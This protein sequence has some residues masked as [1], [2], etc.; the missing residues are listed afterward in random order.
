MRRPP[1]FSTA[2]IAVTLLTPSILF[3]WGH[4]GH[5]IV[6]SLAQTRLT[7]NAKNGIRSLI[8]DAGLASISNWADDVRPDRDETYNWHFVDI[9]KDASGFSDERDCFLPNNKHKGSATD[10]HNC[11]VDRIE[12]FKTVLSNNNAAT[13]RLS[14]T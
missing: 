9:S 5:E 12:L 3:G 13:W 6:A 1:T 4:E 8:G 11:V 14:D 10:H 7:E 2:V